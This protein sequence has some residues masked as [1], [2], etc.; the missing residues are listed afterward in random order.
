[1]QLNRSMVGSIV[2]PVFLRFCMV[3]VINTLIN[4]GLFLFLLNVLQWYYLLAGALGFLAGAVCGFFLNKKFTFQANI[5]NT[6]IFHYL[7]VNIF[8]LF[9]N[10]LVQ[11]IMVDFFA[12]SAHY[13]QLFGI[14]VTT[15]SNF[16]LAKRFVYQA[17]QL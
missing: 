1:M 10:M 15:F 5:S 9:L 3:G 4:Y 12:I 14:I 17:P 13:S 11:Y 16:L 6:K 2:S 8:G 7:L